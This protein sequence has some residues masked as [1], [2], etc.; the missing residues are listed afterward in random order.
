MYKIYSDS[1]IEMTHR[2]RDDISF[3]EVDELY[4]VHEDTGDRVDNTEFN[5]ADCDAFK[6]Q[7][8]VNNIINA[9][10]IAQKQQYNN[11]RCTVDH[12]SYDYTYARTKGPL[13]YRSLGEQ[14][15]M[16]YWD[17]TNGTTTWADHI[18]SVKTAYPKPS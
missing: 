11:E 6:E 8:R 12:A 7:V 14:M 4:A 3:F 13:G 9:G 15:D 18:Q 1:N 2:R 17:N 10:S 16:Q 5:Q